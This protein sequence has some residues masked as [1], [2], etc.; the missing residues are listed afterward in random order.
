MEPD[1]RNADLIVQALELE[2]ANNEGT[3]GDHEPKRKDGENEEELES[4]EATRY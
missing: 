3:P 2:S 1:Q 4:K